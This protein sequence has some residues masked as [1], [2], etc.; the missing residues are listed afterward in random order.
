[1]V[2]GFISSVSDACVRFL[3]L[4]GFLSFFSQVPSQVENF[5]TFLHSSGKGLE[6]D[7]SPHAL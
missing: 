6:N 2:G 1:M 3:P 7:F 5:R 4:R